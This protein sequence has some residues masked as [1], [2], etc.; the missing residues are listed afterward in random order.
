[1]NGY[2]VGLVAVGI[3]TLIVLARLAAKDNAT[4]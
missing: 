1:V 2:L 3:V 4:W